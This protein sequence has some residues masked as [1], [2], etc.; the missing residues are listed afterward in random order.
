MFRGRLGEGKHEKGKLI[1]P[2]GS[3]KK[4]KKRIHNNIH[5]AEEGCW[6]NGEPS[7]IKRYNTEET[8]KRQPLADCIKCQIFLQKDKIRQN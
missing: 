8:D 5:I 6:C 4:K 3:K 1:R 7:N 2:K